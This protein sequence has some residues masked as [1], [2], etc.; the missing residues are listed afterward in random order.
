MVICIWLS[1]FSI[2]QQRSATDLW[3]PLAGP[4]AASYS[5]AP[6]RWSNHR[7]VMVHGGYSTWRCH[8][9]LWT[10]DIHHGVIGVH[11]AT[12]YRVYYH[13]YIPSCTSKYPLMA[14]NYGLMVI[15]SIRANKSFQ[16]SWILRP[17]HGKGSILS[18]ILIDC[19]GLN[20]LI[21]TDP[22]FFIYQS[23]Y[24]ILLILL[25]IVFWCV[26]LF[27]TINIV[28][29]PYQRLTTTDPLPINHQPLLWHH[30]CP[31]Y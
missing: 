2:V 14:M 20:W 25:P 7:C 10:G 13:G 18:I 22:Y 28:M 27:V 4:M 26:F 30:N 11:P 31:A 24:I 5:L 21:Y 9:Q 8:V 23:S 19:S 12:V 17:Y 3:L 16:Y 1:L 15:D 6:Q 29:N